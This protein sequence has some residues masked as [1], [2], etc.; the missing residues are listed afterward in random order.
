MERYEKKR[1]HIAHKYPDQHAL[2]ANY[3][4]EIVDFSPQLIEMLENIKNR[5]NLMK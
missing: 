5:F 2:T 1:N 4:N 3:L